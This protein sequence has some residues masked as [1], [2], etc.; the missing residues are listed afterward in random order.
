MP[1]STAVSQD[2]PESVAK[3]LP[4]KIQTDQSDQQKNYSSEDQSS[5]SDPATIGLA[6]EDIRRVIE[7]QHQQSQLLTTKLNILFAV[8]SGGLLIAL[9][10]SKLILIPSVFS[11]AEMVGFMI[12]F[13]LLLSAFLPRQVAVTPNL[14]NVEVVERYL[15]LSKTNYQLQI[16]VNLVET[17]NVNK[18]RLDDKSKSLTYAAYSTFGIVVVITLHV[19]SL[20]YR[21]NFD[22]P[23]F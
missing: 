22:I 2:L 16:I 12:T 1:D 20:Y 15:N 13:A 11:V 14:G 10:I 6:L 23:E 21:S 4:N 9:A 19:L 7:Q 3:A 5:Q 17:Y 18:Q 8:N